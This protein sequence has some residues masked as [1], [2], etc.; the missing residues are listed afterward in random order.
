[1]RYGCLIFRHISYPSLPKANKVRWDD[2]S[3]VDGTKTTWEDG[4]TLSTTSWDKSQRRIRREKAAMSLEIDVLHT[5]DIHNTLTYFREQ[6]GY[7]K[8]KRLRAEPESNFLEEMNR[9]LIRHQVNLPATYT[10]RTQRSSTRQKT[11][12]S[13]ANSSS[14]AL[15]RSRSN[16]SSVASIG[17]GAEK[18]PPS[19]RS[20]PASSSHSG[21]LSPSLTHCLDSSE[22]LAMHLPMKR[23]R[24]RVESPDSDAAVGPSIRSSHKVASSSASQSR[25]SK[26]PAIGLVVIFSVISCVLRS[27]CA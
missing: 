21:R 13:L 5:T 4:S 15:L 24:K 19:F 9:N 14:S 26:T 25:P 22:S 18:P 16:Q 27:A 17:S 20:T 10:S 12:I 2:W 1:M 7:E 6:A 8:A 3:R 23:S 11:G